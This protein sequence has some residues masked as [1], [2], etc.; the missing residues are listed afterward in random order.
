[1]VFAVANY[2]QISLLCDV[3]SKISTKTF[4]RRVRYR[5]SFVSVVYRPHSQKTSHTSRT[6]HYCHLRCRVKIDR[7]KYRELHLYLSIYTQGQISPIIHNIFC[8]LSVVYWMS[9]KF[10]RRVKLHKGNWKEL[11]NEK[12]TKMSRVCEI[13][14]M[15]ICWI[16]AIPWHVFG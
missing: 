9:H 16:S 14:F 10:I 1:M 8:E 11:F 3:F 4:F 5:V 7:V 12:W 15:G 2:C 13:T 6:I